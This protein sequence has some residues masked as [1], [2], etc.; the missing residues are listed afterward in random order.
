MTP[1]VG[2]ISFGL[3]AG[4][5]L[6]LTLLLAVRW[7]GRAQGVRLVIACSLTCAWAALYAAMIVADVASI[8]F[9]AVAEIL[10][11]GAWITVLTG[12]AGAI[13][14]SRRFLAAVHVALAVALLVAL[15]LPRIFRAPEDQLAALV[16]AG[17]GLSLL[18]LVMLEQVYRNAQFEQKYS[19]RYL[20]VAVALLFGYDLFVYAEAQMVHGI[21]ENSWS[22]RGFVA[23]ITVPLI[24]IAARR[25]PQWALNIFVSRQVVFYSATFMAVGIY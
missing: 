17:I 24:A 20:V 13:G 6:L 5:F 2:L 18:G 7:E 14:V 16:V 22:A 9:A 25:N 1:S 3:A 11:A 10:R 4:C 19:L 21:E 8:Q 12:L 15:A 23:A